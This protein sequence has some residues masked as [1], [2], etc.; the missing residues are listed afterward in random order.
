MEAMELGGCNQ[1]DLPAL[2]HCPFRATVSQF[3]R[4]SL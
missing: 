2:L 4:F 3:A 1:Q